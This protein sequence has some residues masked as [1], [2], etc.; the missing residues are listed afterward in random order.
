VNR[1]ALDAVA[2]VLC[3]A[4]VPVVHRVGPVLRAPYW[5]DESWVALSSKAPL[6]ALPTTTSSTPIGWT[7]LVWLVPPHGQIQRLIPLAFL[8]GS[9]VAGYAFGRVLGSPLCGAAGAAAVLLLP[10]QQARHDLKQYTADAAVALL[11][12]ALLAWAES[13]WSG[14][15]AAILGSAVVGGMLVSHAAALAGVA[16]LAGLLVW[17]ARR[18][19]V[20]GALAAAGCTAAGMALVHLLADR[21]ARNPALAGY[22]AGWFPSPAA[23]PRYVV[24]R[25]GELRPAIGIPWVLWPRSGWRRSRCGSGGPGR[26]SRSPWRGSRSPTGVRRHRRAAGG[27]TSGCRPLTWQCIATPATWCW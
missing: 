22:W 16:V 18:R 20:A 19:R 25:L 5:L 4:S 13:A 7:F 2:V 1:R 23:L 24:E 6:G 21:P 3:L 9:V 17:S 8:A 11:L 27:R 12:F 14:R 26:S 10:A 15:R